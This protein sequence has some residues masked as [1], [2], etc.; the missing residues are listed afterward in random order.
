MESG[1]ALQAL[2][3]TPYVLRSL[4]QRPDADFSC[5]LCSQRGVWDQPEVVFCTFIFYVFTRDPLVAYVYLSRVCR[6][7]RVRNGEMADYWWVFLPFE[8]Q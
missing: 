7:D 2:N 8:S 4:P 3:H 1:P 5:S 6:V